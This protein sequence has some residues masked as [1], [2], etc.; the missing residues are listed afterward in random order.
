M[1]SW[2]LAPWKS[3]IPVLEC[4]PVPSCEPPWS[5]DFRHY[6]PFLRILCCYFYQLGRSSDEGASSGLSPDWRRINYC[7]REPL[8]L[9]KRLVL[10]TGGVTGSLWLRLAEPRQKTAARGHN[11]TLTDSLYLLHILYCGTEAAT[12]FRRSLFLTARHGEWME[13]QLLSVSSHAAVASYYSA[14]T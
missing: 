11:L 4:E 3:E 2:I 14:V 6:L 1:F 8:K 10:F 5:F 12:H 7:A 13:N 9:P